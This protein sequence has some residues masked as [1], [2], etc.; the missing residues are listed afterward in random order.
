MKWLRLYKRFLTALMYNP[1]VA[2]NLANRL[3]LKKNISIRCFNLQVY[4]SLVIKQT[5]DIC[6]AIGLEPFLNYGSLLGYYR[7]NALIDTDNDID[8]GIF[9]Q[10]KP[11]LPQLKEAMIARGYKVRIEN[12]L[13][14]SFKC[15][16]YGNVTV[17]FWIH[18]LHQ[19]SNK[20]FSG[21]F[22]H[23]VKEVSIFPFSPEI[24]HR[25]Q[26]VRFHNVQVYIPHNPEEYL[27]NVYGKDWRIP[28]DKEYSFD[29]KTKFIY[30]NKL[31]ITESEFKLGNFL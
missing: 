18:Y 15:K 1:L 5:M 12:K 2:M 26:S 11:K 23:N 27:V 6:R 16:K 31:M 3:L 29:E 8:F 4:G 21:C 20:I 13:E 7:N 30:P 25:L 9:E 28:L 24:F 17:D 22:F 14:V 10:D 19:R